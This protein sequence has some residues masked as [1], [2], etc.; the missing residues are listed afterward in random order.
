[1]LR[2]RCVV[3]GVTAS[4]CIDHPNVSVS[5]DLCQRYWVCETINAW[6]TTCCLSSHTHWFQWTS[7]CPVQPLV[8][9]TSTH[10]DDGP[11]CLRGWFICPISPHQHIHRCVTYMCESHT[12]EQDEEIGAKWGLTTSVIWKVL[13]FLKL[14]FSRRATSTAK[15]C[16]RPA[17]DGSTT[18]LF[19]H[20]PN[21][22]TVAQR[23][24]LQTTI[25]YFFYYYYHCYEAHKSNTST[26]HYKS[27]K[28]GVLVCV[29]FCGCC[30][31]TMRRFGE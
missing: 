2:C 21:E 12:S 5:K 29:M 18:N 22:C 20:H 23:L 4:P 14:D 6:V 30:L 17:E 11:G 13:R 26:Y 1:M 9:R 7:F 16:R 31:V 3:W 27:R 8:S 25:F 19:S 28:A 24:Q 10:S 15:T